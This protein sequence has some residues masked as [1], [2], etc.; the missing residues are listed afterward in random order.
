MA[1]AIDS[2]LDAALDAGFAVFSEAVTIGVTAAQ[3]IVTSASLNDVYVDGGVGNSD[4]RTI[5]ITKADFPTMPEEK[6]NC[7]ARGVVMQVVSVDDKLRHWV[8]HVQDGAT[9]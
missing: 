4:G 3:G 5:T 9:L 7:T 1:T 6:S 8:L 2:E